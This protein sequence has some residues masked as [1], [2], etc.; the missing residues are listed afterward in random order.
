M[1]V[2]VSVDNESFKVKPPGWKVPEIKRRTAGLWKEIELEKLA[3]FNGNKGHAIIPAHLVGGISTADCVA[4]Q[5]FAVDFDHGATF[6]E[7]KKRCDKNGLRIAYAYHTLSFSSSE[8]KFRIVFVCEEVVEDLF[9]IKAVLWMLNKIFP[10]CDHSC[11][12]PD[13]MF[14]GGKELIHL[15]VSVRMALVQLFPPLMQSLDVGKHFAENMRKFAADTGILLT[16]KHLA[17]GKVEDMDAILGDF[18]DSAVIHKTGKSTK[19][20][21]FIVEAGRFCT[22]AIHFIVSGT[23]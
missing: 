23:I 5:L 4:M 18:V 10:E 16:D 22:K 6:A 20:P 14:F 11:K 8:E 7:I 12:N 2:K 19:S 9:I 3:D 1:K 13:R 17:M 15:D 21:F